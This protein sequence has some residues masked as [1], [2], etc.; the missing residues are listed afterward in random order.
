VDPVVQE[1]FDF[2]R[3]GGTDIVSFITTVNSKGQLVTRQVST[4]VEDGFTV[5]TFSA[6]N[7]LKNRHIPNNPNVTYTWVALKPSRPARAVYLSGIAEVVRD[8]EAIAAFE[9][10][11][12]AH[13]GP[14]R[15]GNPP[16]RVLISVKPVLLRADGFGTGPIPIVTIRDF[17]NP[18]AEPV[19]LEG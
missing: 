3:Q 5:G 12:E 13:Y 15:G 19:N 1:I 16:G 6:P 18:V 4:F 11:R 10:R 9:K 17:T 8:P 2:V 7:A 14:M